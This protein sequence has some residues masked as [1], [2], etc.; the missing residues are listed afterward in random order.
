MQLLK[1]HDT[2]YTVS[3]SDIKHHCEYLGYHSSY[4]IK[5]VER[6]LNEMMY[7]KEVQNFAIEAGKLVITK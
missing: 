6:T 5:D 1:W 2:E 7:S 3:I 4:F